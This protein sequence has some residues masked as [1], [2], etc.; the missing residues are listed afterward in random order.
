MES[1]HLPAEVSQANTMHNDYTFS[2]HC[3]LIV[4]QHV[5]DT[6]PYK[7]RWMDM[8]NDIMSHF[9]TPVNTS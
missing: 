1:P 5:F 8:K 3:G 9:F 6:V 4:G 2:L 7:Y